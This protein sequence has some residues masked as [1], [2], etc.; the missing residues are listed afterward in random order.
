MLEPAVRA[1]ANGAPAVA[2]AAPEPLLRIEDLVVH[3]SVGGGPFSRSDR[4]IHA[5]EGV[6]LTIS[7]GETV[8]LVGESGCG[9]STMARAVVRLLEPTA[10]RIIVGGVDVTHLGRR[11]L[12]PLRRELQMVF[13]DPYGSLNPRL[14]ISEIIAE[15]L[16]I[17]G[18]FPKGTGRAR[19]DEVMSLVGLTSEYAKRYP[20]QL[21]GG[22]RQRVGIAR[23]L[24]LNPKVLILDEPV[25]ALDV[26]IQAQVINLLEDIQGRLGIAFLFIAHNLSV[27]RQISD[28]V[29]VMY[30][31]KIMESGTRSQVYSRPAHPYTRALLSAAPVADPTVKGRRQRITLK[32]DVPSPADPPSG[33]VFHTRCWLRE[34][35][36]N[37]SRCVTEV[38]ALVDLAGTG[39]SVA[40]HFPERTGDPIIRRSAVAPLPVPVAAVGAEGV[41]PTGVSVS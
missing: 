26:S 40:C 5:V 31:G 19:V 7:A 30:L 12:R 37:P 32:G 28:R 38:P 39:Q 9:K 21:S 24:A 14:P 8:G 1:T 16:K 27:V 13:Q 20:H 29:V 34:Q 10:G 15:P 33:C 11:A 35:L 41:P 18:Q 25:S 2:P 23:A 4:R 36:D 6:S 3:Y 17:H 22:Q